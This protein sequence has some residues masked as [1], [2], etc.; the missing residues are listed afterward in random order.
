MVETGDIYPRTKYQSPGNCEA[1][2]Y[3][4]VDGGPVATRQLLQCCE[5]NST[6]EA[7]KVAAEENKV[8]AE[9]G[10]CRQGGTGESS[11]GWGGAACKCRWQQFGS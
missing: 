8:A 10:V 5:N 7:E 3:T 2:F 6:A 4:A 9:D 11:G 1:L